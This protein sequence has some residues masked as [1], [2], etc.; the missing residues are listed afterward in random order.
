MDDMERMMLNLPRLQHLELIADCNNDVVDGQRWQMEAKSLTT[1]NFIFNLRCQL[2]SQHFDSFRTSFWLEE[3][4]WFVAYTHKRLFSVPRFISGETDKD[5]SLPLYSTVSDNTIFYE[6]IDTMY[7]EE[8]SDN[9]KYYFNHVQTLDL[10]FPI[11]LSTLE[12]IVD[13]S[14][15][16]NL[17]LS[18]SLTN[19]PMN[20][21]LNKMSNMCKISITLDKTYFLEQVYCESMKKIHTLKIQNAFMKNEDYNI[22]QLCNVFP[23]IKH[24]YVNHICLKI[25]IFEF[26]YRFK[27]LSTASF[28]Y[29]EVLSDSD[30]EHMQQC[31]LKLQSALD[32]VR[33]R[34][35][36]NYTYRFDNLSVHI[37]VR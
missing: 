9:I 37:W 5:F 13:L 2:E 25:Q 8:I 30:E 7:L 4:R 28:E 33:S 35:R 29:V 32:Q 18:F 23:N 17:N 1:F 3:K 19:F 31:R 20:L 12:K 24:L 10:S 14:R 11:H 27:H 36:L 26:L 22:E 15:I 21:L 34:Q 16:Q 6:C